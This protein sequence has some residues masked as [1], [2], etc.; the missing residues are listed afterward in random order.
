M[1]TKI[2][3][4]A[5]A[6]SLIPFSGVSSEE[7]TYEG[8]I[9][10]TGTYTGIKAGEGGEAKFT[11]Y[12]DLRQGAGLYGRAKLLIDS[13]NPFLK[14]EASDIAYDTQRYILEGGFWGKFK[15][16]L[17][18]QEIPHNITFDARSFYSGA[19]TDTLTGVPNPFVDF[20]NTFDY[21]IDRKQYGG[22]FNFN[23]F[24]PFFFDF[25]FQREDRDG[26]KPAGVS[27]G[28]PGDISL[29]LPEPV[30]YTT[31]NLKLEAGYAKNPLFLSFSYF[32][33]N[34]DNSNQTLLFRNPLTGSS[35]KL[36]L[37]PDNDYYKLAFKGALKLP[38]NTK[39]NAIAGTARANSDHPFFPTFDGKVDTTNYDFS[40]TSTPVSFL[41][42]KAYYKYYKRNNKSTDTSETV[43]TFFDYK[44]E[45][46]GGDLGFRLPAK[47]YLTGAYKYVKTKREAVGETDPAAV[48]PFD[49]DNIFSV[50]LRWTGLDFMALRLGYEH[51]DRNAE[52]QTPET[53]AQLARRYAYASQN[54]NTY[55]A[56]VDLFPLDS[57]DLGLAYQHTNSNYP[58]TTYGLTNS[59]LDEFNINVDYLLG[60]IAKLYGYGDFGWVRFSQY[61]SRGGPTL[62]WKAKENDNTY[63]FGV[64]ADL[65]IIPNKLTLHFWQNYV[66]SNGSIDY[67]LVDPA[68]YVVTPGVFGAGLSG[69]GA[70]NDNIDISKWDDYT[71][72]GIAFKIDYLLM[73][74][75]TLFAGY[76][77]ERYDYS[78]AQLNGYQFVPGTSGSNGAYL[79]GAYKDQSYRANLVFAGATFKF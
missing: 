63:G 50:D 26:I 6:V 5:L 59:R 69:I 68:Y 66:K 65:Y 32:Y 58:D 34:F 9:S 74:S 42:G 61:Q 4:F 7:Y 27:T 70:N 56:S 12:R 79:T 38:L 44:I 52:Y 24:K 11:E 20:W 17:F 75:L 73:K 49:R 25:S 21:S 37:P 60:K 23:M 29:E 78:D 8:E 18:F 1:R 3:L 51:L 19:G 31:D 67:T 64:G 10:A 55:K 77:F 76:G 36:T 2:M 57:L 40:L 13:P 39:V 33:S 15:I 47:F 53:E 35:D 48:L 71:K 41:D 16:D 30:D 28:S 43:G 45:S 72:W 22:G 62:D 54:R 14:F 46:F